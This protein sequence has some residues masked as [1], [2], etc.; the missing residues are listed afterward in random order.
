RAHMNLQ[1]RSG[2]FCKEDIKP[3][4]MYE[5]NFV[6]EPVDHTVKAGHEIGLIIFGSDVEQTLRPFEVAHI[7]V[8]LGSLEA[9]VPLALE[10]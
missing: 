8:D 9:K 2:V 4:K 3:G 5:L 1:N 7:E 10:V 6:L